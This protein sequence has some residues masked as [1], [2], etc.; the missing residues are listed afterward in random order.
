MCS[1]QKIYNALETPEDAELHVKLSAAKVVRKGIDPKRNTWDEL[2]E[3]FKKE[4]ANVVKSTTKLVGASGGPVQTS[5]KPIGAISLIHQLV[6]KDDSDDPPK[7]VFVELG[8][9][10]GRFTVGAALYLNVLRLYEQLKHKDRAK[11]AFSVVGY[12][13]D[14]N[15]GNMATQALKRMHGTHKASIDTTTVFHQNVYLLTDLPEDTTHL[16]MINCGFV[17]TL[18]LHILGLIARAKKLKRFTLWLG[19]QTSDS[20][21]RDCLFPAL[22]VDQTTAC[23]RKADAVVFAGSTPLQMYV[24]DLT[25]TLRDHIRAYLDFAS[26]PCTDNNGRT[27]ALSKKYYGKLQRDIATEQL[28]WNGKGKKRVRNPPPEFAL[29]G[30]CHKKV[31]EIENLKREQKKCRR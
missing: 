1:I 12:E 9:G 24:F 13:L 6:G 26:Q 30:K 3:L 25:A 19:H 2:Y 10:T 23:P 29:V 17:P 31:M 7:R 27:V 11:G 5:T 8:A 4:M 16:L 15:T 21:F 18:Q 22:V 14:E 20:I 28:N